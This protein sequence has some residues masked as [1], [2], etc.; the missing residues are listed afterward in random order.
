[1]KIKYLIV[2]LTFPLFI[3]SQNIDEGLKTQLQKID[4]IIES[5]NKT[6]TKY[7]EGIIEGSIIYSGLFKKNGGWD[8]YYL[9]DKKNPKI[10]L[11]IRYNLALSKTYENYNFYYLNGE[12]IYTRLSVKYYRRKKKNQSFERKYYF[13]NSTLI[14]DTNPENENYDPENIIKK[15]KMTR[16]IIFK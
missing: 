7:S 16:E 11:R 12:L 13:K 5:I 8:A 1:M 9:Y 10:P 14:L 6:D 3:F 15:E 2:F 4:S